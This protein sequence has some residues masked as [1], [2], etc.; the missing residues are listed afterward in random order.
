M[1]TIPRRRFLLRTGALFFGA[2]FL[3]KFYN[4]LESLILKK[5][6]ASRISS[7][8]GSEDPRHHYAHNE[9]FDK[10]NLTENECRATFP[11]LTKEI[12][13][14]VARGSFNLTKAPDGHTG[15]VQGQIKDGKVRIDQ[16][17]EKAMLTVA[18]VCDICRKGS[19]S[20]DEMGTVIP[21]HCTTSV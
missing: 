6:L 19:E 18:A 21:F 10:L 11:D 12:D 7:G 5:L 4:I 20:T 8:N 2:I 3:C 13:D 15:L 16:K 17:K 1:V 14:A 9:L